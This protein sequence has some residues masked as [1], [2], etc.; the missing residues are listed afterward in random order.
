MKCRTQELEE[1]SIS[2]YLS[3]HTKQPLT[4][5]AHSASPFRGEGE[6]ADRE[7]RVSNSHTVGE[8]MKW[9]ANFRFSLPPPISC[10]TLPPS[11][12]T[13]PSHLQPPPSFSISYSIPSTL[14]AAAAAAAS[15]GA[16]AVVGNKSKW[17]GHC[18]NH[19]AAVGFLLAMHTYGMPS[20]TCVGTGASPG[21]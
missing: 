19:L 11:S 4:K 20:A 18:P 6:K 17:R 2:V 12:L 14:L 10:G 15:A 13:S 21:H 8:I 16:E 3:A 7:S 5:V 1:Q 9:T